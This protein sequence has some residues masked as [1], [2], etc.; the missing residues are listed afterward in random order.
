MRCIYSTCFFVFKEKSQTERGEEGR[1]LANE[2]KRGHACRPCV[3][4][5]QLNSTLSD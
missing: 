5:V 2:S 3:W 1:K 4:E